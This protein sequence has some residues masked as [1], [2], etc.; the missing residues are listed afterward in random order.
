MCEVDARRQRFTGLPD[1]TY[2]LSRAGREP[3]MRVAFFSTKPYDRRA[4]AAP[5]LAAGHAVT[6]LEP[7]LDAATASLAVGHEAVCVFVN[8]DLDRAALGVLAAGGTRLVALRCTGFNNVDLAAAAELGLAVT[9][10]AA[11]SPYSVAEYT[12]G[13]LLA[14]DRRIHRAY[15]RVREGNFSLDGLLG[16]DLHGKTVGVIGTGMIGAIVARIFRAG[17]GC[18]VLAHDVREDPALQAI[19]VRYARPLEIAEAADI[20][21][22]HCPLTPQ[23]RHIVDSR[24]LAVAKPG[25]ILVNTSRGAL[26]DC[27]AVIAALKSGHLGGAAFDVYEQE[28]ELFFEDLSNEIIQD[29]V[30]MRLVTFPNVIVTG[31]QAYFTR[32]AIDD[33]V[34]S[35]IASLEAFERGL[36]LADAVPATAGLPA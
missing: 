5:A 34:A 36:P 16:F 31:H 6:F 25:L 15:A 10:V 18:E 28:A 13:L 19:G 11:Y 35:T 2:P 17:F 32:E 23:T 7:R 33:I 14:L 21:T 24:S 30:F 1:P 12:V 22:L 20:I 3:S 29:E 27:E 26:V 4:F 8:D 9:R